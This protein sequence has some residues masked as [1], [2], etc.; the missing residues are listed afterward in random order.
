MILEDYFS[1]PLAYRFLEREQRILRQVRLLARFPLVLEGESLFFEGKIETV[2]RGGKRQEYALRIVVPRGYPVDAVFP[3][4]PDLV[5]FR[6]PHMFSSGRPCLAETGHLGA[7]D[8]AETVYSLIK[9]SA[10]WTWA[11]EVWRASG[12]WPGPEH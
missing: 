4:M 12:V 3:V 6:P 8:L 10:E 9:R 7:D 11:F 1:N 2:G 5:P